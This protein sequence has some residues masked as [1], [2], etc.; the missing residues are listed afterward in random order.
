VTPPDELGPEPDSLRLDMAAFGRALVRRRQAIGWTRY[1]LSRRA[2]MS[3]PYVRTLEHGQ[4][5]R[6]GIEVVVRLAGALGIG[7]DDLLRDAGLPVQTGLP[8]ELRDVYV[9]L[10][11]AERRAWLSIGRALL[12]LQEDHRKL[13]ALPAEDEP[14]V[15]NE[16]LAAYD[17]DLPESESWPEAP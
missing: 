12:D 7:A 4:G 9:Q 15:V 13:Q 17:R 6:V 2:G 8:A 16:P 10:G 3:D 1:R 5:K 11:G 14:L